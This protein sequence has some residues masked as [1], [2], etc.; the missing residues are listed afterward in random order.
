MYNK[1]F[2][3]GEEAMEQIATKLWNKNF[4][5]LTIGQIISLFANGI[6]R[7]ALPLHV[8][9][10]TDSAELMGRVLALSIIPMAILSPFGGALADRVNKKRIIVFLDLITAAITL[11]YLWTIGFLSIVPIT[12][13]ALM[14]FSCIKT[15]MSAATDASVPSIVPANELVRANSV[16]MTINALSM[17]LGPTLGGVLMAGFGL[18][19]ILIVSG[20]CLALAAVME[21]FIRIPN[22]KQKS[23]GNMIVDVTKDIVDGFRFAIVKKPI[24]AKILLSIA[25]INLFVASIAFIGLPVVILRDLGMSERMLGISMGF[26]AAGGLAG[27]IVAGIIGQKLRIQKAY[28]TLVIV[29]ILILPLCLVFF[30]VEYAFIAYCLITAIMFLIGGIISVFTVQVMTFVQLTTPVE[31]LGKIMGLVMLASLLAQPLGNW[32]IG[33]LFDRL[34]ENSWIV[35]LASGILTILIA[36]WSRIY[37]KSLPT[38][39]SEEFNKV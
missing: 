31:L 2:F 15:M 30:M 3:K 20:I 17:L 28:W 33:A 14:L 13:I 38:E 8:F 7:F 19:A 23:S 36:L 25:G 22:V 32:L 29:G 34:G 12:V 1:L 24:I 4:T 39:S 16:T 18:E 37:F 11:F 35:L 10:I 6:L 21:F 27:G 5:M 9:L 26:S